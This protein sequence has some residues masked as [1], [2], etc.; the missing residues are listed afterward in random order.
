MVAFDRFSL[1]CYVAIDFTQFNGDPRNKESLHYCNPE[2]DEPNQYE[3]A[4]RAV[5]EI[6]QDYD[7]DNIFPALGFGA[8]LPPDGKV[9]QTKIILRAKSKCICL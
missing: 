6:I 2:A 9:T 5:G 1:N 3:L 8:R 4:I 7:S